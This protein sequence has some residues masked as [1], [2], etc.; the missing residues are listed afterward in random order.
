MS[1]GSL[2]NIKTKYQVTNDIIT[3]GAKIFLPKGL[4]VNRY[5]PQK[6]SPQYPENDKHRY[7]ERNQN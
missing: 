4:Q 1:I 5:T 6:E 3:E 2:P 7:L